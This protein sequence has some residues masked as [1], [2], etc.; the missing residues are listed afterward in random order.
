M[1]EEKKELE[2]GSINL[3]IRGRKR[4]RE[5]KVLEPRSLTRSRQ[6]AGTLYEGL[7]IGFGRQ[8]RQEYVISGKSRKYINTPLHYWGI[9]VYRCT[10]IL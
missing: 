4:A 2:R 3:S 7:Y 8:A 1:K 5:G 9:A 10:R 6:D